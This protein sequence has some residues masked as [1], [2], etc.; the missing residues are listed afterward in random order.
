MICPSESLEGLTMRDLK[1]YFSDSTIV[2]SLRGLTDHK[3]HSAIAY[4][5]VS[6][7]R[8]GFFQLIGW[9]R[10]F[11]SWKCLRIDYKFP[12]W[13]QRDLYSLAYHIFAIAEQL[14]KRRLLD[15]NRWCILSALQL[16]EPEY[17]GAS[18]LYDRY[19]LYGFN[20]QPSIMRSLDDVFDVIIILL[21]STSL[22]PWYTSLV[23][24]TKHITWSAESSWVKLQL[25][26][27][28]QRKEKLAGA[29]ETG[30]L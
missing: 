25:R 7:P 27:S 11:L 19:L 2:R 8:K 23:C 30:F 4:V 6:T 10:C 5:E 18:S 22:R 17:F 15:Q 16:L 28:L 14:R 13:A 26:I 1:E 21:A 24:H 3:F 29:L 20:P 12:R 9:K